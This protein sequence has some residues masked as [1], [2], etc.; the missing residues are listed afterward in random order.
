MVNAVTAELQL[1]QGQVVGAA[2]TLADLPAAVEARSEQENLTMARLLLAQD[3]PLAAHKLLHQLEQTARKQGRLGSL[4][5]IYV[6]QA[7]TNQALQQFAT[8]DPL[9]EALSLAVQLGYHRTLLND[10]QALAPQLIR[11]RDIAPDFVDSLLDA[12]P[13]LSSDTA[14]ALF[15]PL[16]KTQ[17][18]ILGLV[19]EGLSNQEIADRMGITVGTTKWHLNQIYHILNVSSR[20]QAMAEA[21]RLSLL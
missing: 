16:S 20:T 18:I 21:K 9:R 6:L 3:Q 17:L 12:V 15:E 8:P 2:Y 5:A 10:A 4:I 11:R 14:T 1:R 19:A 7:L 13:G